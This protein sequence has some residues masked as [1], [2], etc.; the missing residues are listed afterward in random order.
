MYGSPGLPVGQ[1]VLVEFVSEGGFSE[2]WRARDSLV[3]NREVL[4]RLVPRH[5]NEYSWFERERLALSRLDPEFVFLLY[6]AGSVEDFDYLVFE[7]ISGRPFREMLKEGEGLS[8][9]E[10][11]PILRGILL[12]LDHIHSSQVFHRD[13]KPDNIYILSNGRVK[14]SDFSLAKL[15]SLNDSNPI[16]ID[17]GDPKELVIGTLTYMPPEQ[18][19]GEGNVDARTDLYQFGVIMYETLTGKRPFNADTPINFMLAHQQEEPPSLV[20][21]QP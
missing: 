11:L 12:A 9:D 19:M 13:L 8:L 5:K 6:S 21:R 1:Y 3:G 16:T 20:A 14:L 10:A 17:F 4:I 18:C 2:L 15:R 7:P